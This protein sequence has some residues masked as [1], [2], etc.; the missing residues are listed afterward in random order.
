[1]AN[2][3]KFYNKN[4]AYK[5]LV[6]IIAILLL[7]F[8]FPKKEIFKYEFSEGK[9]WSYGNLFSPFNFLVPKNSQDINLE[10]KYL[11][12][13]PKIFCIKNEEIVRN[14]KKKIKKISFIRKNKHYY[15]VIYRIINTVYKYGY[16]ENYNNNF[17]KQENKTYIIFFKYKKKWIP[18]SYKKIFTHSKVSKIIEN[19]FRSKNYRANILKKILIKII[20]PNLFYSQYHTDF[21][22]HK[23][24][25]SI[26]KIKYSFT[27]GDNIINNHDIINKNKFK[28][29][30]YFK[31][32]YENKVWNQRKYYGL[33]IGYFLMISII[34]SLFILYI[35]Y[36][37]K[38]IFHNNR[39]VNFLVINILL[40][41]LITITILKYHSKILYIIPFCILPI[42]IR[43]FFNFNLSIFI[44]LITILL[45]SLITPNSFEF[46]FLQITAGFLVMLTKKNIYK[47]AN[48]FMAAVKITITYTITFSLLTLIREGSLVKISL[49]TFYLFFFSGVLTL[50]VHPLIFLFEKL[51]NLTSDISLLELSDTNTPILRLL[52]QKAPGTLQH[53]LTVANIAEEAAV[54]IEANSLLVRIGAI[55]HDIGKIKNAIFFTENQYNIIDPHENLSPKESAKIILEHVS[56]GVELAKKYHLPDSVT[57]FIRTHHGNSVVHYFYDK[58]KKIH[59]NIKVDKKQFQYS[60]PK[61]FSKETAI[62]MIADSVEAASKSIKNPSTKDLENL[63]ENIIKKQKIENQFSNADITLKEIEKIKEVLKKKLMNIYHTRI[64]YPNP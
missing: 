62:V 48:L 4:I 14:I 28:I 58:Q 22:F 1:M 11:K 45:L 41:S 20:V 13:N 40:I 7:T 50:F 9:T 10:I 38:K 16:I 32:E 42:S 2:F 60:G 51:L 33:V 35:F 43:A 5:I 27:K 8:F 15:N 39:E 29:L 56:I 36:F 19:N 53:V 64:V 55:Y 63:V 17:I 57:D 37:E 34:F 47:M 46:I 31:K 23:K 6:I 21:F 49:Y 44:H 18:I 24:I 3:F 54:A 25:Q 26:K 61:P 12:N 30:S 59:P 52:S